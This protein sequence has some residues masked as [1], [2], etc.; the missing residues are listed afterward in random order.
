MV[1]AI[2]SSHRGAIVVESA[3]GAGTTFDLY[4]P[5]APA[6][7]PA[8]GPGSPPPMREGVVPFGNGRLLMIVDDEQSVLSRS[9]RAS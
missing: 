6:Q 1:H 3:L 7:A 9:P 8:P 4:F 2:V 5:P